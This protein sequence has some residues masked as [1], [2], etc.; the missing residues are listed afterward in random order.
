MHMGSAVYENKPHTLSVMEMSSFFTPKR[1]LSKDVNLYESCM[2][3]GAPKKIGSTDKKKKTILSSKRLL[4]W[5][6]HRF[7]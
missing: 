5:I 7:R 1:I 3:Y 2:C 6:L 4:I